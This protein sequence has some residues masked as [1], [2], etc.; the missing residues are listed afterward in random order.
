MVLVQKKKK[1]KIKIKWKPQV[2]PHMQG[3]SKN[4]KVPKFIRTFSL[5][6]FDIYTY[7][8][9]IA[10]FILNINIRKHGNNLKKSFILHRFIQTKSKV[11][12]M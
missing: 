6:N 2:D 3:L 12:T 1:K 5:P 10:P 11:E 9:K 8:N 7:Y 4:I